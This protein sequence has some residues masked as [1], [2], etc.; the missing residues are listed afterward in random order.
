MSTKIINPRLYK[1]GPRK[2]DRRTDGKDLM[3]DILDTIIKRGAVRVT[4]FGSFK[5]IHCKPRGNRTING[6]SYYVGAYNKIKFTPTDNL[7]NSIQHH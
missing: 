5:V 4:G 3:R 7:R 2:K 1:Y 6:Q